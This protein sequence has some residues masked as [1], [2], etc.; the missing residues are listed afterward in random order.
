MWVGWDFIDR[1][2]RKDFSPGT[3]LRAS[4]RFII[5]APV[6][7]AISQLLTDSAGVPVA[8]LLGAVPTGKLF[9]LM[10]VMLARSA[11]TEVLG[12]GNVSDLEKLQCIG[13]SH[14]DR[15]REEGLTTIL[16]LAYVDPIELTMRTNYSF[17]Y[18]AD[19]VSQALAWIYLEDNLALARKY[20]LRGAYEINYIMDPYYQDEEPDLKDK[21]EKVL[22]C[23][24]TELKLQPEALRWTLETIAEDPYSLFICHVWGDELDPTI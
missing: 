17:S 22:D 11:K 19:C 8:F 21:A 4:F 23:L 7:Y 20:S 12:S 2:R 14:A 10:R 3:V 15:F 6:G 9:P 18:V 16:Q 24:S 1:M 5:A 13:G